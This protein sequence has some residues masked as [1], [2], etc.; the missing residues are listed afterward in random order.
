MDCSILAVGGTS[1]YSVRADEGTQ[2]RSS[3]AMPEITL[4]AMVPRL[5]GVAGCIGL[6]QAVEGGL[7]LSSAGL[8]VPDAAV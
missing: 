7:F 2:S 3:V 4:L 8:A 1:V 5:A 6:F